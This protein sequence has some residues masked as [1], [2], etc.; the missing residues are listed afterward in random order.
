MGLKLS[1]HRDQ[2][3]SRSVTRLLLVHCHLGTGPTSQNSPLHSWVPPGS[4]SLLPRTPNSH[5]SISCTKYCH[6]RENVSGGP[7]LLHFACCYFVC[8]YLCVCVCVYIYVYIY[9][10]YCTNKLTFYKIGA[11]FISWGKS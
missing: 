1:P 11:T 6:C 5:N 8:V 9:P 3:A 7:L 10:M 4:H 2:V